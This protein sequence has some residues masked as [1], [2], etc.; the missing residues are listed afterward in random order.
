M[1]DDEEFDKLYSDIRKQKRRDKPI[2][3][4]KTGYEDWTPG[5]RLYDAEDK[6][7]DAKVKKIPVDDYIELQK[8]M[9]RTSS[10]NITPE[11]EFYKADPNY[12]FGEWQ[13][14]YDKRKRKFY[15]HNEVIIPPVFY[16]QEGKLLNNQEGFRRAAYLKYMGVQEVPVIFTKDMHRDSRLSRVTPK[17]KKYENWEEI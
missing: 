12:I 17:N 1:Y 15:P 4:G 3:F 2:T 10:P 6:E 8:D 5:G 16:G 11:E 9:W 7:Y 14:S 13:D